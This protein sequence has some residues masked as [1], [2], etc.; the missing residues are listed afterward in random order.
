V[1]RVERIAAKITRRSWRGIE[2][3]GYSCIPCLPID[4]G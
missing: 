2:P 4:S 1:V 3:D